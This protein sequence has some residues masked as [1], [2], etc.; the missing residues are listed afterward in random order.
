MMK[1]KKMWERTDVSVRIHEIN[2]KISSLKDTLDATDYKVIK[3]V[4]AELA[5]T[6]PPYEIHALHKT[7][8][9]IREKI[10]RLERE[11]EDIRNDDA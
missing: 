7:R 9:S 2:Q 4:E 10:N 5:H 1:G 3:C 6:E 8:Q 11:L